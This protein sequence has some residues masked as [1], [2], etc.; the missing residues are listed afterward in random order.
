MAVLPIRNGLPTLTA[1]STSLPTLPPKAV[2]CGKVMERQQ[3][4]YWFATF[5]LLAGATETM[6]LI[7]P[8]CLTTTEPSTSP[9]TTTAMAANSGKAMVH[10]LVQFESKTYM[11]VQLVQIPMISLPSTIASIFLPIAL[12]TVGKSGKPMEHL[13]VPSALLTKTSGIWKSLPLLATI[14]FSLTKT[15]NSG[16]LTEPIWEPV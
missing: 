15:T 12:P 6:A 14:Y 1:L 3:G 5:V 2:N 10:L 8:T 13:L 16:K 7:R 9:L 4:Q 11:A